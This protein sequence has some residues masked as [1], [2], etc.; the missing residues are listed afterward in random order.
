[1]AW[2][3]TPAQLRAKERY[4][5]KLSEINKR[6]KEIHQNTIKRLSRAEK[7]KY[8]GIFFHIYLTDFCKPRKIKPIVVILLMI[9]DFYEVFVYSQLQDWGLAETNEEIG[10]WI[11]RLRK[12][13]YTEKEMNKN[14]H[15]FL[16]LKSRNLLRDFHAYYDKRLE[17]QAEKNANGHERLVVYFSRGDMNKIIEKNKAKGIK[18]QRTRG[19]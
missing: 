6:A 13:K 1:M 8:H 12:E 4:Y 9:M 15:Y 14:A 16:T 5:E 19:W 17:E 7:S 11:K 2:S 3:D 10:H 18:I